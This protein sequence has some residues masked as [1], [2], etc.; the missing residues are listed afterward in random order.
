MVHVFSWACIGHNV[1]SAW[2]VLIQL[3]G[4]SINMH[5]L[6]YLLELYLLRCLPRNLKRV[7]KNLLQFHKIT[8]KSI[9]IIIIIHAKTVGIILPLCMCFGWRELCVLPTLCTVTCIIYVYPFSLHPSSGC[10]SCCCQV[11]HQAFLPRSLRLQHS[12]HGLH[13]RLLSHSLSAQEQ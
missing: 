1:P 9:I 4:G 12:P 8:A 3:W 13:Q 2:D 5:I 6:T 10:A 11:L 7:V